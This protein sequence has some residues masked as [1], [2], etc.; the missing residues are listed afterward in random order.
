MQGV[1]DFF[2]YACESHK[3]TEAATSTSLVSHVPK[4]T[5]IIIIWNISFDKENLM[6]VLRWLKYGDLSIFAF[7]F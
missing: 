5:I 2:H 6:F 4:L 1:E 7:V 3:S